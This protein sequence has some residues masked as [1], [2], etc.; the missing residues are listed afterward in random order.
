MNSFACNQVSAVA[1]GQ[2][3]LAFHSSKVLTAE[4]V[5]DIDGKDVDFKK[6]AGKVLLFVN[7]ASQ[8]SDPPTHRC[9]DATLSVLV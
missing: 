9:S 4:R 8:V 1:Q 7:L 5:Q 3:H 2:S 6:Y